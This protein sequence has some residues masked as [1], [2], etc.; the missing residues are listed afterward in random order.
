MPVRL[1]PGVRVLG[2]RGEIMFA[3]LA[4]DEVYAEYAEELVIT[5]VTDGRHMRGSLHHCG[6][7][8]DC[9]LPKHN[10]DSIVA[11]IQRRIGVHYDVVLESD[12]IHVEFDYK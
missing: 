4:V 11:E 3:V 2:I 5:S 9:R 8:M 7:A 1:K 12:H 10:L 6:L